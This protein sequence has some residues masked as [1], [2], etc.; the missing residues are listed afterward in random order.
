MDKQQPERDDVALTRNESKP[1]TLGE[2]YS[3]M[4]TPDIAEM[5]EHAERLAKEAAPDPDL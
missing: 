1:D 5:N 4:V 3:E 2:V